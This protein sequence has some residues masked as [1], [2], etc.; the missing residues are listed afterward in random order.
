M[1]DSPVLIVEDEPLVLMGLEDL[2]IDA[3]YSVLLASSAK[4]AEAA[5]AAADGLSAL[6]TDIRLG[7]GETGWWLARLARTRFPRLP[8]I[9]I[10]GDAVS[11]WESNGVTGSVMMQKPVEDRQLVR[12]LDRLVD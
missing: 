2:L 3:G 5:M 12:E 10:S 9:Y 11:E 7:P 6:L 8:V 4:E 1:G